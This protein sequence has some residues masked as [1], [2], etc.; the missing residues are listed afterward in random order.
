[1]AGYYP[2]DQRQWL[3]QIGQGLRIYYADII[4]AA[5]LPERLTALLEQ[6]EEA[7]DNRRQAA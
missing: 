5:P 4:A 1:M 6:L 7:T 2:Q 3:L